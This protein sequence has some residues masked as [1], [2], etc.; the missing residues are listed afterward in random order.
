MNAGFTRSTF[1]MA[2]PRRATALTALA[3]AVGAALLIVATP[4]PASAHDDL[5]SSTP[6]SGQTVAESP[7]TVTMDFSAEILDEVAAGAII[8][9]ITDSAGGLVSEGDPVVDET[10]VIQ[11]LRPGLP[12]GD[13]TVTWRVVSSDGHPIASDFHFFLTSPAP[14][15]APE[16]TPTHAQVQATAAPSAPT[17]PSATPSHSET[18]APTGVRDEAVTGG[19]FPLLIIVAILFIFLVAIVMVLMLRRQRRSHDA[20]ADP[21]EETREDR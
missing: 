10:T 3:F 16:Q 17:T 15:P 13:Y 20:R 1:P 14:A 6:E 11:Q 2:N 8:V 4:A 9:E 5:V 18:A 21:T 7:A 19:L 12:D